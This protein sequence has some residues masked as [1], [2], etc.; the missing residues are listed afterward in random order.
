M[1]ITKIETHVLLI[2]D[3]DP[4]ACSSAQDDLVVL[5]HTDEGITG[6]GEVDTNPWVAQTMI[7]AQGTHVLG[8]GLE[9]MLIGQD[10]L[11]PEALWDRLYTGSLMTGRRGL[12]I[13]AMG[14]LDMALWDIRGK[15][16]G[17]R[18]GTSWAAPENLS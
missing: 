3:Y 7:H 5:I 17:S 16:W 18:A 15:E 13:C 6:I 2:P 8:L 14:A 4:E 10:P 11:Q 9:E 12:G 1:K